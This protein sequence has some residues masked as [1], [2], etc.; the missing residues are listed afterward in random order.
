M[1]EKIAVIGSKDSILVFKSVGCDIY[2][3]N[4]EETARQALNKAIAKYKV[5][6]ITDD[7]AKF[8]EDIINDTKNDA[9]PV[10]LVIPSGNSN[11]S[12]ALDKINEDVERSLGVNI[13]KNKE[14]N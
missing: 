4:N 14:K 1:E 8:T 2:G 6:M 11:S 5:I 9:Y 7:F 3:V 12:Y 10:V 13:L